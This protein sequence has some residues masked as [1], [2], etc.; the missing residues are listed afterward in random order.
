MRAPG[1]RTAVLGVRAA[2]EGSEDV[3]AALAAAMAD[4]YSAVRWL[5]AERLGSIR[6][7]GGLQEQPPAVRAVLAN[8]L[9]DRNPLVRGAARAAL[10]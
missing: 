7:R 5:A 2:D 9:H 4:P 10:G 1:W 6:D 3:T 8:A